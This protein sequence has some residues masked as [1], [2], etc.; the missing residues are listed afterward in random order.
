MA[1]VLVICGSLRK[2]SYNAALAR[3]LPALGPE[4]MRFTPA[5][6]FDLIPHYNHDDQ[7]A[8]GF[9]GWGQAQ[10]G[11]SGRSSPCSRV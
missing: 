6:P 4:G 11:T 1:N 5:P 8:S 7:D 2:K 3:A 10:S 9:Q